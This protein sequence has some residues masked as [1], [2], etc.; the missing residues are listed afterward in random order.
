MGEGSFKKLLQDKG[1]THLISCD[2]AG[3]SSYHI[4]EPPDERMRQTAKKH[5]V[6]LEHAAR[7]L[8]KE[9]F[10]AFD[11]IIAMDS[12]NFHNI[13][14]LS[15]T[16]STPRSQILM[17]RQFDPGHLTE[18]VPDPYFGGLDGFEEVYDIVTRSCTNLL[19]H[20]LKEQGLS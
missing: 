17:M 2:S 14:L 12:K 7:Q 1:L 11:Y 20:I 3:T 15:E 6:K 19:N 10:N 4:G 16:V 13:K 8:S 9:D 18:D 5:G